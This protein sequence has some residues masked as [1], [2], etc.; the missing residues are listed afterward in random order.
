MNFFG[1]V[2][3]GP[4]FFIVPALGGLIASYIWR[5]LKPT[6][7][8]TALNTLWMTLLALVV[9][10]IFFGEGA[11]CLLILSPIFYAMIFVGALLG[12]IWFKVDTNKLYVSVFPLLAVIALGEPFARVDKESVITDEIIIRAPATKVWREVTSFPEITSAPRFWLFR[13]GLPY[14]MSTTSEGDFV[15]AERQC[16]FSDKAIFK[17]RVAELVP[18]EKLTF[19]IYE[20]PQDPELIGHLTPHRG[21]FILRSNADGTTTLVGSTW[22]TLHVRPVWYFD[23]WT[24][25]IFRAVHLRVM[26]D[27]R[28]RAELSQ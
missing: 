11:I 8:A 20:S 26:E 3:G 14:P 15:N 13:I 23:L 4:S 27:I 28:R 22:Y 10:A 9:A 19:E 24:Q 18:R 5:H 12:R 1:S 2:V 25:H 21:Q 7:G 16:I 6:I 17:E